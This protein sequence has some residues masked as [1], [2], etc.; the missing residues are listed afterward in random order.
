[1]AGCPATS[2][3]W[4]RSPGR[5]GVEWPRPHHRRRC[6]P[7]CCESPS[8]A[9]LRNRSRS[10]LPA[11]CVQQRVRAARRSVCGLGAHDE[12]HGR[13]GACGGGASGRVRASRHRR[14]GRESDV[15]CGRR[16]R[17][18][19][20]RVRRWRP[21]DGAPVRRGAASGEGRRRP[22]RRERRYA[23]ERR[24]GGLH[25]VDNG[26]ARLP[27]RDRFTSSSR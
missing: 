21:A 17:T 26:H 20:H 23:A 22:D 13:C 1:M 4:K 16:A 18:R 15:R 14:T 27:R 5:L 24:L 8:T 11:R 9:V 6:G 10:W 2:R 12:R 19:A 7:A 3:G 25:R